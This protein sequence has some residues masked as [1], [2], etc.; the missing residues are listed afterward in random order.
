MA[1]CG[2][3]SFFIRLDFRTGS[4]F[5]QAGLYVF[6]V[7]RISFLYVVITSYDSSLRGKRSGVRFLYNEHKNGHK[8]TLYACAYTYAYV[9]AHLVPRASDPFGQREEFYV[10]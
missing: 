6:N 7:C 10:T 2:E 8:N 4:T 3:G 5:E 9:M 1:G